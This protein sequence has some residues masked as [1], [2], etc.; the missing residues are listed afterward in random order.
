MTTISYLNLSNTSEL[1]SAIKGIDLFS[2]E[3]G[4]TGIHYLITLQAGATLT[5]SAEISAINLKGS[6]TLTI[7]GQGAA[8]DGAALIA[9]CSPIQARRRSR[10]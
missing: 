9:A 4:G 3:S 7:N 6:D 1:S 5:E 2:Q 10:T 8:I